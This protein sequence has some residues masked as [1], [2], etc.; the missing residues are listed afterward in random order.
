MSA[1]TPGAGAALELARPAHSRRLATG[2]WRFARSSPAATA[3][4]VL[5]LFFAALAIAGVAEHSAAY[6]QNLMER[7]DP[8][9]TAGHLLGT[10]TLGRDVLARIMNAVR[11]SLEIGAAAVAIAGTVGVV[12]GMVAGFVG[13]WVDDLIMRIS[14]SVLAIPIVLLALS[15]LVVIGGG[16]RNLIIVIAFT[17]W[18][19][20]ARTARAETL[21]L[22]Q[23]DFVRAARALGASRTRILRRNILP[24]LLPSAIALATLNVSVAIL[25]EA[26]LSYLGLGVQ[27]PD[28]SL[29]SMLTEG[30]QYIF[31][32]S[33]LAI[34]PGLALLLLVLA[35]NLLGDGL[36]TFLDPRAHHRSSEVKPL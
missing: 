33:W 14:D 1:T 10:D 34:Y 16:I 6:N 31:V 11:I 15:V 4:L 30:R 19:T 35:I 24:H 22:R 21:A 17:Q 12:L 9:G 7:L 25:L 32:A 27:P 36:S 2:F 8:P 3:G 13:G 26:G 28:P 18:M 20:Y 29:G 23:Q 5:V